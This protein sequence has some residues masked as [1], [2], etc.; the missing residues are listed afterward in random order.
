MC[1]MGQSISDVV[2]K[3]RERVQVFTTSNIER[4]IIKHDKG[5]GGSVKMPQNYR[6]LPLSTY[7]P[8]V[9]GGGQASFTFLLHITCKKMGGGRGSRKHVK[10]R[11]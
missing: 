1:D 7:A 5:E 2:S 8:R 10:M 11:M 6:D 3:G 4:C 9:R